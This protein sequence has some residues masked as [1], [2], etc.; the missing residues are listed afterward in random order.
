MRKNRWV[1]LG[2][3]FVMAC[4]F[5]GCGGKKNKEV[6]FGEGVE[7]SFETEKMQ[8]ETCIM[9]VGKEEVRL[10]EF[11]FYVYQL[12]SI[13]DGS[14]TSAVWD[15]V[16][17]DGGS[18]GQYSKEELVKE[19]AQVKIICQQ[20]REE[21]YSLSEQETNEACVMAGKYVENLPAE[22][23]DYNLIRPLVEKIY[24]EHALAKKMY[25]VV[26]GTV[27]T[28]I[29]DDEARQMTV[30]Y[31]KILTKGTDRNGIE[32]NLSAEQKKSAHRRAKELLKNA[33][34]KENF[35]AY[36]AENS[37]DLETTLTFSKTTGPKD[38]VDVAFSLKDGEC[39]SLIETDTGYYILY[40]EKAYDEEKTME[41]KE[42]VIK[43]RENKAFREAYDSWKQNYKILVSETLLSEIRLGVENQEVVQE[44]K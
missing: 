28:M 31:I 33:E 1:A 41:Y 37:D 2:L 8:L 24:L 7:S 40:C 4:S 12:K 11:L 3:T 30:S 32:V 43:E 15:Y 35:S 21:G 20:A 23:K 38:L 13:Y 19:I 26:A 36:A 42:K 10:N 39:S 9:T 6:I 14:L 27:D 29:P 25:D 18:I 22:A 17:P 5:S 34:K 16:L 44:Q